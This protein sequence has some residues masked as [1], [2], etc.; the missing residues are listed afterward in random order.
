MDNQP[1]PRQRR[2]RIGS[3]A[4]STPPRTE[5][6]YHWNRIIAAAL[7]LL[8][9]LVLLGL[10][11][12]A[13]LSDPAPAPA[14]GDA[15]ID[16]SEAPATD[17]EAVPP[18]REPEIAETAPQP[19]EPEALRTPGAA[20][21]AEVPLQEETVREFPEIAETLQQEQEQEPSTVFLPPETR[22][23]LRAD[24]SLASPVLRILE[25]GTELELLDIGEDFYQV[26][27]EHG[28]V[29]WVSR[30]FSSVAPYPV[31]EP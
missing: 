21:S 5:Y 11:I 8:L 19:A 26:R 7:V 29:G 31:S 4:A 17:L 22:V 24:P 12:R 10:G 9:I 28:V 16:A 25:P 13:W 18:S 27:S 14:L 15:A 3:G 2:N 6:I 20:P 1:P 23:N 30:D